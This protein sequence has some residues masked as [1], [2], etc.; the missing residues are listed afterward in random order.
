M[1]VTRL[2]MTSRS[3]K[4]RGRAPPLRLCS[5]I[6]SE[7]GPP[8]SY[9]VGPHMGYYHHMAPHFTPGTSA[10]PNDLIASWKQSSHS[11]FCRKARSA[12]NLRQYKLHSLSGTF[13][14]NY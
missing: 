14:D 2:D 12:E 4:S 1:S 5:R 3:F 8:G 13:K 10:G 7:T 11:D 6:A 9:A